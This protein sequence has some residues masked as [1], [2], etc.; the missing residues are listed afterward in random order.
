MPERYTPALKIVCLGLA[1]LMVAQMARLAARK[2]PLEQL[3]FS[4]LAIL[5]ADAEKEAGTKDTNSVPPAR[6]TKQDAAPAPIMVS[7]EFGPNSSN[8]IAMGQKG[9]KIRPPLPASSGGSM[10]T[11]VPPAVQTRID[12]IVQSEILGPVLSRLPL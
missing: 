10:T 6:A 12:H 7:V 11:D 1:A 5:P 4:A 9:T 2:D 3:S 8:L